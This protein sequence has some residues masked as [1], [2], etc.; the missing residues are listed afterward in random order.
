[1]RT[2]EH[3]PLFLERG[4]SNTEAHQKPVELGFRKGK[5][6]V[7]FGRILRGDDHKGLLKRMR[8]I[9]DGNLCF[10]HRFQETALGLRRGAIDLVGQHD[11]GKDRTRYELKPLFLPVKHGDADDVGRQQIAGELNA[12]ER[13]VKR[14]GQAVCQC[15]FADARNVFEQK[16]ATGQKADHR[17]LDH[18]GFPL[19]DQRDIVLDCPDGVR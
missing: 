3:L 4:I 15:G 11:V 10:T 14:S 1:M 9:I 5:R 19:D 13:T 7:I 6:P 2:V 18:M 16:M 12:L 17:H 8:L